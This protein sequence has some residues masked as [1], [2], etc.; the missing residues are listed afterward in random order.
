MSNKKTAFHVKDMDCPSEEQMILVAAL[1]LV[2]NIIS[3]LIINKA[4]SSEAHMQASAI[5]TS[6][7][8]IVNVGEIAAG[9]LVYTLD[10]RLP[11]LLVGG[12][13]FSFVMKGAVKILKLSY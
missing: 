11:D 12:I 2:A 8:I 3:L 13:V 10:S 5:F 6:N 1:A 7:D 4:K 9:G